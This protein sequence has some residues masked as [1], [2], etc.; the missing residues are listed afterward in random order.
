M[1]KSRERQSNFE[2]LRIFAMAVIVIHHACVHSGFTFQ[3]PS[4]NKIIVEML[5][6]GG[7]AW[8]RYFCTDFGLFSYREEK[9]SIKEGIHVMGTGFLLFF[10]ISRYGFIFS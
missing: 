9:W 10:F 7:K 4:L 6:I 5:E 8:R 2:L 1:D 3:K